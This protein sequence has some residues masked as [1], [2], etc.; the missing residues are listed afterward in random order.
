MNA[1][2]Y[3]QEGQLDEAVAAVTAEVKANPSN[4]DGRW[5]LTEL[6]CFKGDFDRADKQL[7]ILLTQAPEAALNTA[8]FRQLL[9]AE[10]SRR[11]FFTHGRVPEFIDG[12]TAALQLHLEAALC[13]REGNSVEA[14]RLLAQAEQQQPTV[15]GE[16]NGEAFEGIRDCDDLTASFLEVLTSNGKYYWVPW[17]R[18]ETIE[19]RAPETPRDLIWQ[20]VHLI[21]RSGP[22]GEV[23]LPVLYYGSD[24]AST[25]GLKLG[26]AT[27]FL[28][29]SSGLVRGVGQRT[30]WCGEVDCPI[31]EMKTLNIDEPQP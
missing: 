26:R 3:F 17:E 9:R 21:V 12:A 10:V 30:I 18:I 23:Y 29:E 4:L 2:E 14:T 11:E 16:C 8:L 24:Q 5:F 7:D 15:R 27:D 1:K 22:D 31:L 6:L 20:R 28:E 25:S 19:F 13:L